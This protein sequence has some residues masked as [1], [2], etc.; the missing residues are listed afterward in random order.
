M[1]EVPEK[2][3][4][5]GKFLIPCIL[6]DRE[7]CNSLANS[8]A[9]INLM[10]LSIYEKLEIRALKPTRMTLELANRS[11]TFL[12]GIVEDVIVIVENFNFLADF[13]IVDFE[14]DPRVPIILGRPFCALQVGMAIKP[15]YSQVPRLFPRGVNQ[16]HPQ[17]A[18]F[19]LS[20]PFENEDKVFN[21][22]ILI[23]GGTQ[24]F[25]DESKDKD[26][27]VNTSSEAFLILEER[28]FLSH[29]SDRYSDRE[30]LF[31]LKSYVIE[32]LLS[33]SSEN[34]DKVFNPEI[35]ISKGVHSSTLGLSHRTYETFKIV[36]GVTHRPND[37]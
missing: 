34:E 10:P 31:F 18:H 7:V 33:F 23:L 22:G 32:T 2:L 3:D 28:I 11:V 4:D 1:D 15:F 8:R 12:M 29:Y 24:I 14:A 25:N 17:I 13:I 30:L 19:L 37:L 35:P 26:F 9:S 36:N 6:Q 16:G 20:S 27:K 5:H 21:P